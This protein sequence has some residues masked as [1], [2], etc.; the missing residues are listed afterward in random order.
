MKKSENWTAPSRLLETN[1]FAN[2]DP[3]DHGTQGAIHTTAY[4]FYPDIV[5]PFFK[6]VQNLGVKINKAMVS[7]NFIITVNMIFITFL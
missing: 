7:A 5:T 3:Q 1:F 4:T 2:N 6:A